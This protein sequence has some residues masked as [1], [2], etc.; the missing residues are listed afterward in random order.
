MRP[1][2]LLLALLAAVPSVPAAENTLSPAE[3]RDGWQLLFDGR[4]WSGW[5]AYRQPASA[6]IKG[7]EIVDGMLHCLPGQKGDQPVTARKFRDYELSWDWKILPKGNNGLKY[8]VTEDRPKS[9]GPEYQMIDD[10][11]HP[12]GKLGPKRQTAS[13]YE[14]LAPA[15]D[16]PL[17]AAGQW[18][19]SRLVIRGRQVEHWLNGRKVLAFELGSEE[20]KAGIAGSKFRNEAGFGDKIDGHILLTY[21][22][23]DC[24][25]RNIKLRELKP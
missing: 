11:G 4:S 23:D 17:R 2:P 1:L 15:A 13:F 16:K 10:T 8:L 7:W 22:S 24:W 12:D 18:N 14:V 25:Y 6:P 5:R 21:H 3:R 20:V 9:P 19:T